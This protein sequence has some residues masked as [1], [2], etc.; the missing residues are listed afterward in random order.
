MLVF[1]GDHA[2]DLALMVLV[3]PRALTRI[4]IKHIHLSEEK[5]R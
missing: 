1:A 5:Q 4:V 2:L 3:R